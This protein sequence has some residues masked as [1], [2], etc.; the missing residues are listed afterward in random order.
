[1]KKDALGLALTWD[2][3]RWPI[4]RL[5]PKARAF[6]GRAKSPSP[7]KMALALCDNA[8]EEIRICWVPRLKGGRDVLCDPF[9]TQDDHRLSFQLAKTLPFGDVLGAVYRRI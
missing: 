5:S 8:V 6:L 2:G 1:M 4:T 3:A 9:S 7:A